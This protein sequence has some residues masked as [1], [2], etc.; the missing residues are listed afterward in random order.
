MMTSSRIRKS[1]SNKCI[2]NCRI[3]KPIEG[4][5]KKLF[6]L[7]WYIGATCMAFIRKMLFHVQ[8]NTNKSRAHSCMILCMLL[9]WHIKITLHVLQYCFFLN[10]CNRDKSR[11]YLYYTAFRIEVR[12]VQHFIHKFVNWRHLTQ[13]SKYLNDKMYVVIKQTIATHLNDS[14]Y[15]LFSNPPT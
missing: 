14:E 9:C 3:S 4:V 1:S 5:S 8:I 12:I 10:V 6:T 7:V 11:L 15:V 2:N 13:L